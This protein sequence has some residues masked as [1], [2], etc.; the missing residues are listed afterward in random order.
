MI[1]CDPEKLGERH[2]LNP[3]GRPPISVFEALHHMALQ[4]AVGIFLDLLILR[5]C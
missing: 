4:E 3:E 1:Y 2:Q 5:C